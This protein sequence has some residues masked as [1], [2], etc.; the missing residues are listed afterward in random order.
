MLKHSK[1]IK[2]AWDRYKNNEKIKETLILIHFYSQKYYLQNYII[3]KLNY[4]VNNYCN[5]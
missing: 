4:K 2:I 5:K 1:M 3:N